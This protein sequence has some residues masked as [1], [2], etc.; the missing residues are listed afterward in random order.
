MAGG[1][2]MHTNQSTQP[3][4]KA[5]SDALNILGIDVHLLL[6]SEDTEGQYSTYTCTLPPGDGPPPHKH[7]DFDEAFTVVEGAVDILCDGT[8][9]TL[10]EGETVF[11]PRGA[12]HTFRNSTESTAKFFAVATPGGHEKFFLDACHLGPTSAMEDVV[13]VFTKHRIDIVAPE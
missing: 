13:G 9:R 3:I 8:W 4:V 7:D 10:T 2:N 6:H 11:L 12:V 1:R 5:K